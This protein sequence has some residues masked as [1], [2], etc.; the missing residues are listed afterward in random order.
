MKLAFLSEIS[1][2]LRSDLSEYYL[3]VTFIYE[4]IAFDNVSCYPGF[5]G[6]GYSVIKHESIGTK[7]YVQIVTLSAHELFSMDTIFDNL[8]MNLPPFHVHGSLESASISIVRRDNPHL[9]SKPI[10]ADRW[11]NILNDYT[12]EDLDVIQ[13]KEIG[14]Y[15]LLGENE[16]IKEG[17]KLTQRIRELLLD[18]SPMVKS[19]MLDLVEDLIGDIKRDLDFEDFD[20]NKR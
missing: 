6:I 20:E 8:E 14:I 12:E 17:R 19:L 2:L 4:P 5:M 10:V 15:E 13:P 9:K 7:G 16:K 1:Q 18:Q 3:D 11:G